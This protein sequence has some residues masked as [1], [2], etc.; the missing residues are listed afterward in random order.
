MLGDTTLYKV[1]SGND[2]LRLNV[3]Q[4]LETLLKRHPLTIGTHK[5]YIRDISSRLADLLTVEDREASL[6]ILR[7]YRRVLSHDR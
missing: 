4:S 1:E 7:F 2:K 3:V 5:Q 6:E